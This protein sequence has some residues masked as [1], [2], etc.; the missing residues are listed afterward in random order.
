MSWKK[1]FFAIFFAEGLAIAGFSISMPIIPLFF[2]EL[3]LHT[4]SSVN[5]WNGITQTASAIGLA[6]FAPIWGV[7][8]DRYGRRTMLLRAMFGGAILVGVMTFVTAPWQLLTLRVLQGCVTGTIAAATVLTTSIVP[9]RKIGFCLGLL[10]SSVFVGSAIGP[11]FG[12][13]VSDLYGHRATFVITAIFLFIAGALVTLLVKESFKPGRD[14]ARTRRALPDF[15]IIAADAG[16]ASLLLMIFSIQMAGSVVNP[17]LPLFIQ[18]ITPDVTI[19][20]TATGLILG[21]AALSSAG[22]AAIIGKVSDRH[23]YSM[24]LA[25]CMAGAVLL[26]IPQGFVHSW[27]EL[28]VLRIIDGFFMGGTMPAANALISKR[29]PPEKRGSIFGVCTSVSAL[30]LALGPA[31]GATAASLWGY[32]SVFFITSGILAAASL[33]IFF[34]KTGKIRLG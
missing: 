16:L 24:T 8:A 14:N 18:S 3:G 1:S 23:G 26:Y 32:P 9:E 28:L 20:G 27:Q 22:A 25:I 15:K 7:L 4:E 6:V 11:L 17:I 29:T 5:F 21:I 31:L 13:V 34:V 33:T 10:Q 12:G 2:Q 30:G 19:L